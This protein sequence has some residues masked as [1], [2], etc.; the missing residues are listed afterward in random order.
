MDSRRCVHHLRLDSSG[1]ASVVSPSPL[2]HPSL[3]TVVL[4]ILEA[5]VVGFSPCYQAAFAHGHSLRL[6]IWGGREM[7]TPAKIL[8]LAPVLRKE[9]RVHHTDGSKR[10]LKTFAG[11]VVKLR[12]KAGLTRRD[13]AEQVGIS[14]Y[15][16]ALIEL[17]EYWPT[18]PVYLAICRVLD[19]GVPPLMK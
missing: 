11:A 7:T 9:H 10:T 5:L 19:V 2:A 15:T 3:A 14:Y 12:L 4:A 17:G 18:I 8:A 1:R 6:S 16:A 13:F